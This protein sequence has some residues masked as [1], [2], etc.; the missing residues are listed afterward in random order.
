MPAPTIP[1]GDDELSGRLAELVARRGGKI[2]LVPGGRMIYLPDPDRD[3][4]LTS[5]S[6]PGGGQVWTAAQFSAWVKRRKMRFEGI[7]RLL[8]ARIGARYTSSVVGRWA[9]GTR[10]VPVRI[11]TECAAIDAE[12]RAARA[13]AKRGK[14]A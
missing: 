2:T 12:E 1:A 10:P 13:E 14:A 7:A 11:S 3:P 5:G 4:L 6:V 9:N 8:N